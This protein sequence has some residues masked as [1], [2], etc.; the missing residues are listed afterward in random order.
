VGGALCAHLAAR[1]LRVRRAMR[2]LPAP[3]PGDSIAVGEIGPDTDWDAALRDVNAVVHLAARVHTLRETAADPLAEYR[4]V[5]LDGTRRLAA[6]AARQGVSRLVFVSTSKVNGEASARPF[7]ESD[8]PRPE[9]AYARSKWEAEQALAHIGRET[10]LEHVIL[11]PPLVYGPGVGAN[12]GRLMRWVVRGVPLPLGAVDNRRSL[13]YLGNL[14]DAIRVC[15]D[16]PAAAER[17][18]LV[19]DGEDVSTPELVRRIAG[20]L[21]VAPRLFPVPVS[22][23]RLAASAIGR[24]QEIERLVG[25]LQVD[26]AAIRRELGWSAPATM[27][28]GLTET[29]RW[30][31]Q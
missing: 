17:T 29:A 20:A 16:H 13:L 28:E 10:G 25:S 18:Y 6:A 7:T 11:R 1:G 14:V 24:R 2:A 23:L 27:R 8:S 22:M 15:L 3:V 19:S 12:F 30:F 31:R 26:S 4:R 9:D 21:G 5:N